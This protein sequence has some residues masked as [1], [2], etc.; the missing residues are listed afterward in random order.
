MAKIC[1]DAEASGG[2]ENIHDKKAYLIGKSF[3]EMQFTG[4]SFVVFVIIVAVLKIG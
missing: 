3:E 4:W 1:G 2:I